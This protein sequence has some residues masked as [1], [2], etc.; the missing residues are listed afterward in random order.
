MESGP[1]N[2]KFTGF[3]HQFSYKGNT[4]ER[5]RGGSGEIFNKFSL[6]CE[7]ESVLDVGVLNMDGKVQRCSKSV[8]F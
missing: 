5:E 4:R 3:V 7:S 6:I 8:D 2:F 1:I